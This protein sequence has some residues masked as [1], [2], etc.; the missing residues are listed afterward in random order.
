MLE[1]V[2]AGSPAPSDGDAS[3]AGPP[4]EA[5]VDGAVDAADVDGAAVGD[6]AGDAAVGDAA[7]GADET[8]VPSKLEKRCQA[9]VDR[10]V[11]YVAAQ[12]LRDE[13]CD[14]LLRARRLDELE[15]QRTELSTEL[16]QATQMPPGWASPVTRDEPP[17]LQQHLQYQRT[18]EQQQR[19]RGVAARATDYLLPS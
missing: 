19:E 13:R 3:Q 14:A 12:E 17:H 5:A 11:A 1:A 4:K 2:P 7:G 15:R 10:S 6:A 16:R 9:A 18:E 8:S